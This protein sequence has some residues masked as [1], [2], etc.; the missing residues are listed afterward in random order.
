MSTTM[1]AT[2]LAVADLPVS[3]G[4][5]G[6]GARLGA[7]SDFT[8]VVSAV[9]SVLA[10]PSL[11]VLVSDVPS[12]AVASFAPSLPSVLPACALPPAATCAASANNCSAVRGEAGGG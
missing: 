11:P 3:A 2:R 10:S 9:V 8:V 5:G 12:F 1:A 7:A 6:T 4:A